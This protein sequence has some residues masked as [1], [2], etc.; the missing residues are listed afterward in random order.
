MANKHT[1]IVIASIIVII[2]SLGYSSINAISAHSLEFS[3]PGSSFNFLS[4]M[5]DKKVNVCNDSVLPATFS[6]YSIT[7]FYDGDDLGTFST[8][9]GGL[10]SHT[11]GVVFGEFKSKDDRMSGLFFSFLDTETGGTDVTRIN[12]N[13]IKVVTQLESTI[14]WF[15]PHTI[16]KEYSGSEFLDVINKPTTCEK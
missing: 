6:K 11:D 2:G 13:K 15:I 7:I 4:V 3:W 10:Q 1:I 16:T 12:A 14:L 8:G 9:P 5:T